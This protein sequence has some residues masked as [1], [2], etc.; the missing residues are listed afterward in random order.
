M[1]KPVNYDIA[2]RKK[3]ILKGGSP[4]ANGR[5]FVDLVCPFCGEETRAYVWSLCGE[6]KVCGTKGCKAKF[7]RAG[8]SVPRLSTPG[9]VVV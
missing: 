1:T 6:G 2:G 5:T 8:Y 9:P 7:C 4:R 3:W